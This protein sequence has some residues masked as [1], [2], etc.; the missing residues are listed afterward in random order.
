MRHRWPGDDIPVDDQN[1]CIVC[2]VKR[3]FRSSMADSRRLRALGEPRQPL[4]VEYLVPG[5][6]WSV[7]RPE[8][9]VPGQ[10]HLLAPNPRDGLL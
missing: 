3:R 1:I 9:E 8:C 5:H 6:G 7:Q 2:G 4:I 10:L